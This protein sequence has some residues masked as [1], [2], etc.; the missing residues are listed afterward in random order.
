MSKYAPSSPENV[1]NIKSILLIVF[2]ILSCSKT[3]I[4]LSTHIGVAACVMEIPVRKQR[5]MK[6]LLHILVKAPDGETHMMYF[7]AQNPR[8]RYM[9]HY[10]S[11]QRLSVPELIELGSV[12]LQTAAIVWAL[13]ARK[14]S[15][16]ISGP[17]DPT[18]GVGKTTTMNALLPFL[19]AGSEM[20]YTIG[21]YEDFAFVQETTPAVTTVL[22]NEVSDHLTIYMWGSNAKQLFHLTQQG[23]SIATSC[24][25]DT[26]TDVMAMLRTDLHV[27]ES[28]IA[29]VR[30]IVNIGLTGLD[31]PPQR[32]WLTTHFISPDIPQ[33]SGKAK[34]QL[35][36]SWIQEDDS[37]TAPNPQTLA[38]ICA[39]AGLSAEEFA[40]ELAA[41]EQFLQ[42][43]GAVSYEEA[44]AA[45][46][47][48]HGA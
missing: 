17:T 31:W 3:F 5:L 32:R 9:L 7:D 20:I 30:L 1:Y 24:H 48:Y 18:P 28:D 15:F 6:N 36:T 43:L 40:A 16:I 33:T 38:A 41:R 47:Q 35:I 22:A 37:F 26:I 42:N 44:A 34:P 21:M 13:V 4:N 19:P 2:I 45:I 25:A 46:A 39:W 8:H 23:Y 29:G 12:N 14:A 10:E 27:P 11:Y